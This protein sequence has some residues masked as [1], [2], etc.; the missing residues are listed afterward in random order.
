M[1]PA[2]DFLELIIEPT[3]KHLS[4][5]DERL[6]SPE[7]HD[8]MLG[9]ALA[10]SGLR[11]I[12]QLGGGPALGPYQMEPS[13]HDDIW[14]NYLTSARRLTLS[15]LVREFACSHI[16]RTPDSSQLPGNWFYATA[17]ARLVYWRKDPDPIPKDILG[18]ARVWK[19]FFNTE[20]GK[21]TV[22]KYLEAWKRDGVRYSH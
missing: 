11:A 3:L 18:Q 12:K 22:K 9:T 10:E 19:K 14:K 7:A 4:T 8:L 20:D 16:S 15:R 2:R 6:A 5:Y 21:G 13:T 17:M 1:I